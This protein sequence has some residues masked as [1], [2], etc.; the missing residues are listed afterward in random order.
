MA[1]RHRERWVGRVKFARLETLTMDSYLSR[2]QDICYT[3][4]QLRRTETAYLKN[5][6]KNIIPC[7]K[8]EL[9]RVVSP[10]VRQ[11]LINRVLSGEYPT[12]K[13]QNQ[14]EPVKEKVRRYPFYDEANEEGPVEA[15]AKDSRKCGSV[16]CTGAFTLEIMLSVIVNKDVRELKFPEARR[17]NSICY[18]N[19]VIQ[20]YVSFQVPLVLESY[21]MSLRENPIIKLPEGR[22][23]IFQLQKVKISDTSNFVNSIHESEKQNDLE[24]FRETR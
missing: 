15:M 7:L 19:P 8:Y 23:A 2:L 4:I 12:S 11:C 9:D 10:V 6:T 24:I 1:E 18:V 3:Y 21:M 13:Y 5:V 14:Y 16:C 20:E 22:I 17:K